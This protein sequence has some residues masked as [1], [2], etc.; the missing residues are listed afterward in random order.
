MQDIGCSLVHVPDQICVQTEG[1][2]ESQ[3]NH[4]EKLG[5]HLCILRLQHMNPSLLRSL[6]RG[7]L[8][9][10]GLQLVPKFYVHYV[11]RQLGVL[12][13]NQGQLAKNSPLKINEAHNIRFSAKKTSGLLLISF[14]WVLATTLRYITFTYPSTMA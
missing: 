1:A 3:P 8:V 6:F 5:K 11:R 10:V 9:F 2:Q 12:F 4:I 7:F 14:R 13:E